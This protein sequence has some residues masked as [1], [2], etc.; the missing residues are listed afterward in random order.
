MHTRKVSIYLS[1]SVFVALFPLAGGNWEIR[2]KMTIKQLDSWC[3]IIFQ[4]KKQ[5]AVSKKEMRTFY[6]SC[7][8]TSCSK[9]NHQLM[10]P[11]HT[12]HNPFKANNVKTDI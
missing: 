5:S 11:R 6:F 1:D 4:F 7:A 8:N 9:L 10:I 2:G 3:R 12:S